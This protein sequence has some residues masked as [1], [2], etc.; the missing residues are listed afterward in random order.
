[1]VIGGEEM[2]EA[3]PSSGALKIDARHSDSAGIV[4]VYTGASLSALARIWSSWQGRGGT[5]FITD[6]PTYNIA[7]ASGW[8]IPGRIDFSLEIVAPEAPRI[9]SQP[10]SASLK[11]GDYLYPYVT[12]TGTEPLT[13][14]WR[15]DGSNLPGATNQVLYLENVKIGDAGDY[16]V[17][18]QNQVRSTTSSNATITIVN[19]T[20]IWDLEVEFTDDV[21]DG[22]SNGD[23][24]RIHLLIDSE[25][26]QYEAT[27]TAS[28]SVPF[29]GRIRVNLNLWNP[30]RDL[31]AEPV[32]LVAVFDVETHLPWPRRAL[33][34]SRQS[35]PMLV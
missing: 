18:V 16:S 6:G 24:I 21:G 15:K 13:Y 32:S 17:I 27:V 23:V 11:P 29:F 28:E 8:S 33:G 7:I 30:T 5:F 2:E 31:V 34:C 14:Q 26:G 12:A 9:V 35:L 19:N 3:A 1:M 22:A 25:E 4:A 10:G 20:P